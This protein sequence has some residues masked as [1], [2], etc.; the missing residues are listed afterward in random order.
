M[1]KIKGNIKPL[2]FAMTFPLIGLLYP[3]LNKPGIKTY[4]LATK[5]DA[6]LPFLK[7]FI[8]P[9]IAW[10]PYVI[11]AL[12]YF[13]LRDKKNFYK[14]IIML[15]ICLLLAFSTYVVYQ[16]TVE[17][18]LLVGDDILTKLVGA[19]YNRDNPFNCFPS[20]HVIETYIMMRAMMAMEEKNK[21]INLMIQ[22]IGI[23][24]I[25]STQFIKQHVILDI[26]SSIILVEIV[27][28]IVY[29]L[30]ESYIPQW[31]KNLFSQLTKKEELEI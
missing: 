26:V 25:L 31:I 23:L 27:F 3:I 17:R 6:T 18:P 14:V 16:T 29:R 22:I 15:D 20:L 9:Y 11:L 12:V 21:V 30:K 8:L 4:N 28:N 13:F 10:Y 5:L 19:I 1:N 24:I 2:L 7:I